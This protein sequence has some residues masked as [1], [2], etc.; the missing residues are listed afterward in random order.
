MAFKDAITKFKKKAGPQEKL[1]KPSGAAANSLAS[2]SDAVGQ[3]ARAITQDISQFRSGS[4]SIM[5][6]AERE[7]MRTNRRANRR[8]AE[9]A[10]A[11][12]RAQ[13]NGGVF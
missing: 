2:V 10:S 13:R 4:Q 6:D 5:D 9:Q 1:G 3:E 8:F 11:F 12:R 7:E